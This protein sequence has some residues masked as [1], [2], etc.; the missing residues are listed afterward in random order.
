[1]IDYLALGPLII[2]HLQGSVK[3]AR[4]VL[5]ADDLADAELSGQTLPALHVY[6]VADQI[7]TESNLGANVE[8]DQTW[9]VIVVVRHARL[10]SERRGR[11]GELISEV[12]NVMQGWQPPGNEF[13]ELHRIASPG[14]TYTPGGVAYFPLYFVSRVLQTAT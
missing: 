4:A 3:G 8:S 7:A 2:E 6:Y 9:A 10:A 1:M 12:F 13:G 11:A 5:S 14:P